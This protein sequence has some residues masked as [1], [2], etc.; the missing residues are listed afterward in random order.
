MKLE[1]NENREED[2]SFVPIDTFCIEAT[3][4]TITTDM[5]QSH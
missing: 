1:N 3:A 5:S 4:T 2:C